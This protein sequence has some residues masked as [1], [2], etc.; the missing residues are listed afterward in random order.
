MR[1]FATKL[2]TVLFGAALAAMPILAQ[3][4][5]IDYDHSLNLDKYQTYSWNKIH[6]TDPSLISR[7]SVALN[8]N[9]RSKQMTEK[10]SGSDITIAVVEASESKQELVD[11][12]SGLAG[13]SWQRGWGSGGFLDSPAKIQ[14]IPLGALVVDFYDTKT[15]KLLWRGMVTDTVV[16]SGDKYDQKV[17]KAVNELISK[18]P[19][20]FVK[21]K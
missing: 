18:F 19:P 12:Y 1:S 16:K 9:L 4:A 2:A 13:F 3:T 6:A 11:H 20:K 8:R 15:H 17:D 21:S 14:E 5:T 10:S 7:I